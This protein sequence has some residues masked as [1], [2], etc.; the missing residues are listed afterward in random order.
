M[1]LKDYYHILGVNEDTSIQD[2]KKAFRQLASRYHPD[3]NPDNISDAEARFKEINEA[4]EVLG[5]EQKRWQYDYLRRLSDNAQSGVENN[6]CGYSDPVTLQEMLR[7]FS[8]MGIAFKG[9]GCWSGRG[10]RRQFWQC[11]RQQ[12]RE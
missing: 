9:M 11:H 4:Y 7:R 3:H 1:S 2:I 12:W 5:D 6:P 8:G 10:C